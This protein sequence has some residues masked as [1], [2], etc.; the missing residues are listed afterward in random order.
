MGSKYVQAIENELSIINK[1]AQEIPFVLN[2]PQAHFLENIQNKNIILKARQMGFS[3]VILGYLTI[4]FL[5]KYNERLVVVSHE[6]GATQK[7]MDRV[8]FFISSYERKNKIKL[9]TKYNSRSEIVNEDTNSTIYIGTAG[10]KSF[11]RGDTIT[12]LHLSEFAFYSN[13]EEM[14]AG[15]LQALTPDGN[16][17]IES[18]ANG[19]N[20][21]KTL[22]DE[23]EAR[24]FTK[25]F[26]NS[27]WLY[28][29]DFIK[30]KEKELGRLFKQEYPETPEEAFLTS[31]DMYF[32]GDS[33]KWYLEQ[34]KNPIKENLIYV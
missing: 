12:A 8:K 27:E 13:P 15:V 24:G 4:R 23:A 21:Y 26:Y 2:S 9:P 29:K 31:G 11:G 34:C 16:L 19:F 10:S 3:S 18:T 14:L 17:F 6:A 33:L 7:L 28:D 32:D 1:N 22:W 30:Q 5:L 20:F 25:H